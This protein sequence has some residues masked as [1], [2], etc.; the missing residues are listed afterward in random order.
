VATGSSNSDSGYGSDY[1]SDF[2]SGGSAGGTAQVGLSIPDALLFGLLW[3]FVAAFVAPYVVRRAGG[4]MG[5]SAVTAVPGMTAPPVQGIPPMPGGP[6]PAAAPVPPSPTPSPYDPSSYDPSPS[7]P[8]P[9]DLHTVHLGHQPLPSPSVP[10][11][12]LTSKP[13]SRA[14]VWTVTLAIAFVVGGGA[15]AGVLVW[16]DHRT[17]GASASDD[18]PEATSTPTAQPTQSETP[19]PTPTPTEEPTDKASTEAA[20][21]P[22]SYH[23]LTDPMG[24]SLAV[25]DVWAREG[26]KNGTQVTYAGST[27]LEHIQVGVIANAGYTSYDNFLT[28]EKTAKKKDTDYR[29][30]TLESNTFQG[31]AGAIWE[32][33]YTDESGRTVH[34]KDQSYVADDGTEYAIMLVGYDDMWESDLA[35]TFQVALD[36]WQLT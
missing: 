12:P 17:K 23:Q 21:L 29:R 11:T 10:L 22:D 31:R 20:E 24:F 4:R 1:G 13:R 28:L 5:V 8:S 19:T 15:A 34:A 9:Y 35:G 33:T 18:K 7:D 16:Q 32:Y 36:S 27:G 3:I 25:P 26:V 2:A 6:V 30:I 14:L